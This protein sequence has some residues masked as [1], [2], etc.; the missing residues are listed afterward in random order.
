MAVKFAKLDNKVYTQLPNE[1]RET[2]FWRQQTSDIKFLL[3]DAEEQYVLEMFI[4]QT[5]SHS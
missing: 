3:S 2:G 5:R 4:I 1:K